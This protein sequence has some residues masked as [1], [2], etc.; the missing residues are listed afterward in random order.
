MLIAIRKNKA[1]QTVAVMGSVD[2]ALKAA[3]S[4]IL[5]FSE[6]YARAR[7]R[8]VII[9]KNFNFVNINSHNLSSTGVDGGYN[10]GSK[11]LRSTQRLNRC[12][13]VPPIMA[14]CRL[15]RCAFFYGGVWQAQAPRRRRRLEHPHPFCV[16]FNLKPTEAHMPNSSSI[17]SEQSFDTS[18]IQSTQT[19]STGF[20]PFSWVGKDAT[21]THKHV[22]FAAQAMD[23][24][25]GVALCLEILE[26]DGLEDDQDHPAP[27]LNTYQAGNMRR[28]CITSLQ[29][30]ANK[31]SE[32]L[33]G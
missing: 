26:Y 11:N 9:A 8:G 5:E 17:Q 1:H 28:L 32:V 6:Q 30:L 20:A 7:A 16:D 29:M 22:D 2:N 4:K 12:F 13:F 27:V 21:P 19:P 24:V 18:T 14:A 3:L 25:N 15:T 33:H 31:A 10:G 23:I